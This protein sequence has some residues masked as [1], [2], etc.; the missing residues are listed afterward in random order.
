LPRRFLALIID[1]ICI[2]IIGWAAA[3]LI[4]L[5]GIFTLGLGWLGFHVIPFIPFAYYT[6]LIGGGGA[7]PGQRFARLT[8]RQ[9]DNPALP[10]TLAQALVWAVLLW[11]SFALAGIPFLFA[12]LDP[13][14]RMPH[15]IL[16]G[17]VVIRT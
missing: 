14:G 15:D 12:F 1:V 5:F 9:N 17:L 16:A 8:M 4:I 13:R 7:T 11:L 6:L 3:I 2:N 10:P